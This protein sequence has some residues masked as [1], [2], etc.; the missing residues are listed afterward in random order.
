MDA[1]SY[2]FIIRKTIADL[3]TCIAFYDVASVVWD[4]DFHFNS[5]S[6]INALYPTIQHRN[7]RSVSCS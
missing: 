4:E 7:L 3:Y 6:V 1:L 2:Q 5:N